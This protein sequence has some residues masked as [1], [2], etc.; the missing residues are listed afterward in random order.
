MSKDRIN[1]RASKATRCL[2]H[3][4]EQLRKL[5]PKI[6]AAVIVLLDARAQNKRGGHFKGKAWK[7]RGGKSVPEVAISPTFL[8]RRSYFSPVPFTKP[9]MQFCMRSIAAGVGR[10]ESITTRYSWPRVKDSVRNAALPTD[11]TDGPPRDGK[12]VW[13]RPGI[14][15]S[16]N[17]L[18]ANCPG[19]RESSDRNGFNAPNVPPPVPAL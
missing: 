18:G 2:E 9:L 8:K 7:Y 10:M 4:W 3:V 6:P 17:T 19:E 13:F 14:K 5:E 16:F 12:T 11:D 1:D 15:E